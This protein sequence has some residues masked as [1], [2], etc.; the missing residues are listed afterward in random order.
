MPSDSSN[1]TRFARFHTTRWSVV[2]GAQSPG[3]ADASLESLCRQYWPPLYAYVRSRGH[4][5]HDAQDLTQG[6]FAKLLEKNWL[7]AAD[8]SQGKLRSFLLTAMKRFL[9]NERERA[10]A[11]KRG[12]LHDITSMDTGEGERLLAA[13]ATLPE[14]PAFDRI[15][16]LTVLQATLRR[17]SAEYGQAGKLREYDR[18]KP[19]LTAMRGEIDYDAIAADLHVLPAS[20]RSLVHRLRKR[21]RE[22]F[23]EEVAGTVA[24][25]D[26]ID[27]EMRALV[28]SLGHI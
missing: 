11:A 13:A 22:L 8:R 16:A 25:M 2:V 21:F 12:G 18:I 3:T 20:A 24:T 10:H 26:D 4:P 19:S 7:A 17:L 6:F 5:P 9:A 27:D 28:A 14:Q 15:W 23:R 1:F